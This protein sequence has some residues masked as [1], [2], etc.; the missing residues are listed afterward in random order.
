MIRNEY[1][2]KD[3]HGERRERQVTVQFAAFG[4]VAE[5][6][7]N[8]AYMGDQLIV[9]ASISNNNYTDGGGVERYGFNFEV[10]EV[11]FGAPGP[12][13]RRRLAAASAP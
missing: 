6:L 12:E 8:H 10:N 13:K 2:G 9:S 7:S 1:A 3:E 4:G 11:E 5:M